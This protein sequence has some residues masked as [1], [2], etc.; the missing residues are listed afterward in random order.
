MSIER[1]SMSS[2]N[3]AMPKT[4]SPAAIGVSS[5]RTS[6][7][8]DA[9]NEKNDPL[10]SWS[11]SFGLQTVCLARVPSSPGAHLAGA[12][13]LALLTRVYG[14]GLKPFGAI[15]V[16]LHSRPP[17]APQLVSPSCVSPCWPSLHY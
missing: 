8:M 5:A 4:Y 12:I 6:G 16:R 10:H 11:Q 7:T 17:I 2:R 3:G 14:V 1:C 9:L 15:C 13:P